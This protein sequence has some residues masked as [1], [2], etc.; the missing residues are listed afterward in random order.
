MKKVLIPLI[1]L[2]FLLVMGFGSAFYIVF[3]TPNIAVKTPTTLTIPKSCTY[4]QLLDSLKVKNLL[5]RPWSFE[6]AAKVMKY[7][8]S[9]KRGVYEILP[10]ENNLTLI[11]RLRK[12]QH[13]PVKF[14]FNG[15]R[16][17][18]LFVQKT[19][20]LFLFQPNELLN[21]LN[22]STFLKQYGFTVETC[23]AIFMPNTYELYHDI[24][25][26]EFF[27]KMHENYQQFWTSE[28]RALADS[29]GFSP[30][31]IATIA[32]I[33]EEE[34]YRAAEKAIIAGLYINR[35]HKGMKLQ[36]DPTVKF[37]VGDF[38]LKRILNEHLRTESPYNTYLHTG[39][40]PG[41]IRFAAG[42]TMD[43]VLHYT[44]HNFLFMC[45]KED[46]SG[47]HNFTKSYGQHLNNARKYQ[48]AL[49]AKMRKQ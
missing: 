13:Y 1:V 41:P 19:E 16:T 46:F 11:R 23:P 20:N 28:R 21:L 6:I 25:A 22:D 34:N 24:D 32:S 44:R 40:P 12:G 35:I 4:T 49:T 45:A 29:I 14:T 17:K 48:K 18:E 33:V 9:V 2:L 26:E 38:A 47:Y 3:Y 30:T 39:L 36:A 8:I 5:Q 42:S 15:V 27:A 37:A 10:G 31:E 43:S 7:P